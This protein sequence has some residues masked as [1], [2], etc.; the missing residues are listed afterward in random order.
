MLFTGRYPRLVY[1]YGFV[2]LQSGLQELPEAKKTL[3]VLRN[4]L[5]SLT[6]H[7]RCLIRSPEIFQTPPHVKIRILF[8]KLDRE[9]PTFER[10]TCPKTLNGFTISIRIGI[11]NS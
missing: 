10:Q 1:R 5:Q 2:E 8:L 11:G 3:I 7:L 9:P 4:L 6:I